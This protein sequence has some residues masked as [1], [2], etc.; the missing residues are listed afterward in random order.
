[1]FRAR[2]CYFGAHT[3]LTGKQTGTGAFVHPPRPPSPVLQKHTIPFL[4]PRQS[5]A[6]THGAAGAGQAPCSPAF[7]MARTSHSGPPGRL[8]WWGREQ[9]HSRSQAEPGPAT[10]RHGAQD[11]Q[12]SDWGTRGLRMNRSSLMVVE[13]AARQGIWCQQQ[14]LVRWPEPS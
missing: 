9:G 3:R 8:R 4:F 13:S 6:A 12:P 14:R 2:A 5:V 1:M 11:L 7:R 10:R